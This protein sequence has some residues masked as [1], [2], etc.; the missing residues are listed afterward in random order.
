MNSATLSLDDSQDSTSPSSSPGSVNT[1]EDSEV[2]QGAAAAVPERPEAVPEAEPEAEVIMACQQAMALAMTQAISTMSLDGDER[3][4]NPFPA[5]F[6]II[7]TYFDSIPY[8]DKCSKLL[9]DLLALYSQLEYH[10]LEISVMLFGQDDGIGPASGA[11]QG[12]D[13]L[14][15]LKN[16]LGIIIDGANGQIDYFV[17]KHKTILT[18]LISVMHVCMRHLSLSFM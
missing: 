8:T 6:E 10:D 11:G 15:R 16:A 1:V 14:L 5:I 13:V 3:L 9:E 4:T 12:G 2:Q 7:S 18:Q 17:F